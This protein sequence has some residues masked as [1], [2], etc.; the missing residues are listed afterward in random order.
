MLNERREELA[1]AIHARFLKEQT[2][3]KRPDDP[4]M[5]PW[6]EL[7]ERF[8]VDNREQADDIERK[9]RAVHCGFRPPSPADGATVSFTDAEVETL[10]QMEHE[11]WNEAK[12]RQGYRY[13]PVRSD[14]PPKAHPFLIPWDELPESEKDKDRDPSREIPQF[15]GSVGF[16]VFRL[17]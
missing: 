11:R 1:Q 3:R 14:V 16:H 13:G 8:R 9:L 4:S 10:A 6:E 12:R 2:G 17:D 15:L 7:E 5:K